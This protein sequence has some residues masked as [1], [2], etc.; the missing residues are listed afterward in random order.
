M[1][2][3]LL[4]AM[5]ALGALAVLPFGGNFSG[6]VTASSNDSVVAAE[7]EEIGNVEFIQETED[8][9][10]YAEA[11]SVVTFTKSM[12]ISALPSSVMHRLAERGDITLVM[13]YTYGGVDYTITIP[14]GQAVESD[15][16]WYGPLWLAAHYGNGAAAAGTATG[17]SYT[18]QSNDTMSKIANANGM[19]VAQ[20]AAKNPQITDVNRIV[21]GQ[22]INLK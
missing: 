9:I 20:L 18:V 12:G 7:E 8:M 16:D 13:E 17:D 2:K 22:K 10:D 19:T 21:V 3:K 5:L 14:A 11:G 1:K 15:I 4:V 6:V